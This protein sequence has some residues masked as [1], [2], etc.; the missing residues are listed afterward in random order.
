MTDF[1][2]HGYDTEVRHGKTLIDAAKKAGV[3]HLIWSTFDHSELRVPHFESKAE[4]DGFILFGTEFSKRR[5]PETV[6]S[7]TD[8]T[9]HGFLY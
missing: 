2:E 6:G 5:L 8:F 7:S 9:I 3:K 1:W 4:V